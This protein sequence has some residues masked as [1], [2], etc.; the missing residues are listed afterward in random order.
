MTF[1]E[2]KI[3]LQKK[4]FFLKACLAITIIWLVAL[5]IYSF[6]LI[7]GG[8]SPISFTDIAEFK[9]ISLRYSISRWFDPIFVLAWLIFIAVFA[10]LLQKR[11]LLLADKKLNLKG[12]T[13]CHD[14]PV[15]EKE[16]EEEMLLLDAYFFCFVLGGLGVS[17]WAAIY[18]GAAFYG[19]I[20][21]LFFAIYLYVFIF[22][23]I[24]LWSFCSPI[25]N[26]FSKIIRHKS[27]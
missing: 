20:V 25:I 18:F 15:Q 8:L 9:F 21:H 3:E 23:A 6:S 16:I 14:L 5:V 13:G 11:R 22:V 24:I 26:F 12:R 7:K 1:I 19:L 27:L 4:M 10:W 17:L 2:A